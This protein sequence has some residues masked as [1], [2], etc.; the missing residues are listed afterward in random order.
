MVEQDNKDLD[1]AFDHAVNFVQT[2]KD[3]SVKIT[4]DDRL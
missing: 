4:N 1:K 2:F 3:P